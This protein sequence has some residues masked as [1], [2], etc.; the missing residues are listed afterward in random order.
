[1]THSV[2]EVYSATGFVSQFVGI[3]CGTVS[4]WDYVFSLGF[5]KGVPLPWKWDTLWAAVQRTS[6]NDNRIC[7]PYPKNVAEPVTRVA[8]GHI[9]CGT[10]LCYKIGVWRPLYI[11]E[12]REV[13]FLCQKRSYK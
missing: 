10:G 7:V 3:A 1:M 5:I 2:P 8:C 4:S 13:R 12:F 11:G 9:E 6:E